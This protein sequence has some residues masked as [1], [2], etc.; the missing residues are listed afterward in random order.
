MGITVGSYFSLYDKRAELARIYKKYGARA[1]FIVPARLD[2]DFMLELICGN[3][4]GFGARP[5]VWT[6]GDLL[7][8]LQR[9]TKEYERIIDPPDHK[10][11]LRWLLSVFLA[12]A[13]EKGAALEPGYSHAGFVSVLGENIKDLLAEEVSPG[14]LRSALGEEVGEYSPESV[15]IELYERYTEYLEDYGLAD[16]AQIFTL[17]RRKLLTDAGRVFVEGKKIVFAGFLSFTS[18]QLR[19]VKALGELA[20]LTMLQP[21]TGLDW[22][23]DG[24]LQLNEG[25]KERPKWDV[26]VV[27]I[28]AGN[29]QLELE[30]VARELALWACGEGALTALGEFGGYGSVG[31]MTSPD[32]LHIAE[33]ALSRYKIPYNVQEGGTAGETLLG[34]LPSAIWRA[35]RSGWN[36]RET[37]LLVSNPLLFGWGG[38]LPRYDEG[39]M[40]D[41]MDAWLG[42]LPEDAGETL[43]RADALCEDFE[44]GASP[45]EA[46]SLWRDFLK[47]C[48]AAERA[49]SAAAE[50]SEL[51]GSVKQAA[52]ALDELDKK[53]RKLADDSKDIGPAANITLKGAEAAAFINEWG[54]TATLP[55]QLPQS[56][57]VTVYAGPPP[58]LAS[59]RCWIMT[60]VD[61][62][63]WPGVLR[64]SMLL[65][66]DKKAK[67]NASRP[68]DGEPSHLPELH[69]ER[70]QKEAVFRRILAT[71]RECAV[72]TRALFNENGEECGESRFAASALDGGGERC[73]RVAGSA[74]YPAERSMPDGGGPWFPQAEVVCTPVSRGRPEAQ[75]VGRAAP[76][77]LPRIRVSDIDRWNVCPYMYWCERVLGLESGRPS[78]Y[79]SRKAG[80]LAHLAWEAAFREKEENPKL[81][82]HRYVM[83]NWTSFKTFG[84]PELDSDPRLARY[85]KRL[86]RQ[87]FDMA[88]AQDELEERLAAAPKLATE[89]EVRLD[90]FEF[91]GALFTGQADRIDRFEDGIVV[92]DY[93]LG[94]SRPHEKE[95]QVAAYCAM[96]AAS[97]EENILGFGWL[98]H[99]GPSLSGYFSEKIFDLYKFKDT[100]NKRESFAERIDEALALMADMAESVRKGEYPPRYNVKN[101]VC[102]TCAY[103]TLCRKREKRVYIESLIEEAENDDAE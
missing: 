42:A 60:G 52:S 43:R 30:A 24:I 82:I 72:V 1:I 69:E 13:E 45:E 56:R 17:A 58:T 14:S 36:N 22:F 34:G 95:L 83:D 100:V 90:G 62:N 49:A 19:L 91:A 3:E 78:L 41:G 63:R 33:Y 23:H 5:A 8:E 47:G 26:P 79:D 15:L 2:R 101:R 54:A 71:G 61:S 74:L 81:S 32:R 11:I 44:K 64:E 18:S 92:L 25:Y 48:R 73:W 93:K 94:G 6:V 76:S 29:P 66:N 53:I 98:G 39:S 35:R 27:K 99:A 57:S 37:A 28:D 84:Y 38:E 68:E 40:P 55:V 67:F 65:G 59:H 80:T 31:L 16:A 77:E 4:P 51:D 97:R 75:P 85:E 89:T 46:L 50:L 10:L 96:L 88:A 9:A 7:L 21:E 86:R 70:E 20:D 102:Q 103:F 87:M 12:E